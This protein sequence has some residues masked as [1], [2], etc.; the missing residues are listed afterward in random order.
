V[1]AEPSPLGPHGVG[2]RAV[3]DFLFGPGR[4]GEHT[5]PHIIAA[6]ADI[7]VGDRGDPRTAL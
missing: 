7:F 2:R 4:F 5:G 1:T 6:Y 3:V